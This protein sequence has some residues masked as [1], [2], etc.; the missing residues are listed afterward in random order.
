MSSSWLLIETF[1]GAQPSVIGRGSTQKSFVEL[2]K[3]IRSAATRDEAER[4]VLEVMTTGRSVDRQSEDGRRL[5]LAE[6]L[7]V[8]S[9][10][11]HG[12]WLWI[13]DHDEKVPTR[14]PAGAWLFNLTTS[15]A[16]GSDDLLDLYGVPEDQRPTQ[17]AIAGAF[18]RLVTNRDESEAMAKIVNSVPGDVHQAVWTVRRD[19]EQL[20]AAHFS[21]RMLAEDVGGKTEVILRG[22]THDLGP[23]EDIT[24]APPPTILEHRIL[25]A[26]TKDG[27]YRALVN[28]RTLN[29][30]RWYNSDPVPNICWENVAGEPTPAI[31]PDNLPIA[32]KM[33]KGL[34]HKRTTG[35]VR[36][37]TMDDK[38]KPL[39]LNA[40]LVS[41]DQHTTAALV[42]ITEA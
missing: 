41:L 30:L 15:T 36:F 8:F 7:K 11:V 14:D 27:E 29:L 19:D 4:A 34:A 42:V 23:A 40:S 37:R 16:S 9:E 10:R 39:H 24:I 3:V 6:P 38:W 35:T 13:G 20:R 32:K 22:I 18:T 12:V 21:C 17:R 5:V 33:S 28:L 26:S 25:E 31:H 2:A 1:G